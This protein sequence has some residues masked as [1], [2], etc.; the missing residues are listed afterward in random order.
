MQLVKGQPSSIFDFHTNLTRFVYLFGEELF[1]VASN[2]YVREGGE[3]VRVLVGVG[4]QAK[5]V[6]GG[7]GQVTPGQTPARV[8]SG[9]KKV[10]STRPCL[11]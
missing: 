11:S 8:S 7:R 1:L 9:T 4:E 5:C 2:K 3:D 10:S 6:R